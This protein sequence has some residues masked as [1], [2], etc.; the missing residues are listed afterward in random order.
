MREPLGEPP[1]VDEDDR[2]LVGPDELE[3]PRMDRGPDARP[4]V[5]VRGGATG[6][7]LEREHLAEAAHVLDGH[8]DL[9]LERLARARIDDR[10]LAVRPYPTEET[11]DRVERP[12]R[13]AES[14]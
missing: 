12:L 9:E 5:A 13:R 14:D 8:H 11:G 2:A 6:L 3:D 10:D 7:V 4:H 1:A